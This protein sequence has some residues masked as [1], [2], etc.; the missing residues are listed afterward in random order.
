MGRSRRGDSLRRKHKI[1]AVDPFSKE[2][3]GKAAHLDLESFGSVGLEKPQQGKKSKRSASYDQAPKKGED[4][5]IPSKAKMLMGAAAMEADEPSSKK[6]KCDQKRKDNPRQKIEM[7]KRNVQARPGE[8]FKQYAKRVKQMVRQTLQE[9]DKSIRKTSEKRK[10]HLEK[11]DQK[12]KE[13]KQQKQNSSTGKYNHGVSRKDADSDD[14]EI[15]MPR[16][17][18]AF[19]ERVEAPPNLTRKPQP[20]KSQKRERAVDEDGSGYGDEHHESKVTDTDKTSEME[21]LRA[22]VQGA[23]KAM[24][25]RKAENQRKNRLSA[26]ETNGAKSKKRKT[27]DKPFGFSFDSSL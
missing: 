22:R 17:Y 5:A 8:S 10:A 4:E 12:K 1:K 26:Q 18:V 3:A 13:K 14:E 15:L 7:A 11:R 6:R 2:N 23:Y 24:K 27:T 25:H 21:A 20:P 9:S 19:G 16:D